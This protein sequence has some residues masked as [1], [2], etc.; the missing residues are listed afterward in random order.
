MAEGG[1]VSIDRQKVVSE[2]KQHPWFREYV[3]EFGEEPD[4]SEN[5]DYDYITAWTS[6]IR[7]ERDPY[8][9]NRYHWSSMTSSGAMLKKPGHPTMWKTL[10]MEHTGKNPDAIG[11]KSEQEAQAYINAQRVKKSRG[12]YTPQEELLLMRYANR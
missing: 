6:G 8:D 7:P 12:G 11:I 10:F 9:K 2:I 5:A 3:K 4:L 1:S